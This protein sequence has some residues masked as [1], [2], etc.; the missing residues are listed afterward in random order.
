MSVA[1]DLKPIVNFVLKVFEKNLSITLFSSL[2]FSLYDF[3]YFDILRFE[4]KYKRFDYSL[5]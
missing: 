1:G 2:H 3:Y 5:P 4:S